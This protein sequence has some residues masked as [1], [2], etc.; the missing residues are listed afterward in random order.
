MASEVASQ[1][2]M[3]ARWPVHRDAN[4]V[5]AGLLELASTLCIESSPTGLHADA[6]PFAGQKLDDLVDVLA[7]I[8]LPTDQG[9]LTTAEVNQPLSNVENLLV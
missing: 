2:V 7:E 5:Q 6:Q 3:D 1:L 4:S 9:N 8:S